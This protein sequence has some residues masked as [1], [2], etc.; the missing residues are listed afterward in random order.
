[1]GAAN[2]RG[3]FEQRKAQA[4]EAARIAKIEEATHRVAR[5]RRLSDMHAMGLISDDD[6]KAIMRRSKKSKLSHRTTMMSIY[7]LGMMASWPQVSRN[8][9]GGSE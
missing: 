2:R 9:S 6:H 3:T 1:M 4:I 5:K 7:M 8:R